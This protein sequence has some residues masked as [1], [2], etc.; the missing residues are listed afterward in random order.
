MGV[1]RVGWPAVNRVLHVRCEAGGSGKWGDGGRGGL[2]RLWPLF[3]SPSW[4]NMWL[5]L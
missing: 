4:G 2:L 3:P 1:L 5:M